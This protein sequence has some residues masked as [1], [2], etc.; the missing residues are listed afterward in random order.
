LFLI[1][2]LSLK[3]ALQ[4]KPMRCEWNRMCLNAI[5]YE[6]FSHGLTS[7]GKCLTYWWKHWT[8]VV[9]QCKDV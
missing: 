4:I 5:F 2:V 1:G 9:F 8:I 3:S 7:L 6:I